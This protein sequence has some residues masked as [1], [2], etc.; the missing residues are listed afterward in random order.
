MF[1]YDIINIQDVK[2]IIIN[3]TISNAL[4]YVLDFGETMTRAPADIL[5]LLLVPCT[6]I[7]IK[8]IYENY[9]RFCLNDCILCRLFKHKQR[10]D[11]QVF[12]EQVFSPSVSFIVYSFPIHILFLDFRFIYTRFGFGRQ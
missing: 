1:P 10:R 3:F 11:Q 12:K 6:K 2:R 9:S 4:Y 5:K 7:Y 8:S